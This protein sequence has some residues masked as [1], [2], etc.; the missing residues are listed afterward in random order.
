[1]SGVDASDRS[2]AC[3]EPGMERREP[4]TVPVEGSLAPPRRWR[5]T[6]LAV[7]ATL[8][9]RI[10][11]HCAGLTAD[12]V[13][14]TYRYAHNLGEGRGLVFNPGERV[15]GATEPGVALV[16]GGLHAATGLPVDRLGAAFT[17][18]CLVGLAWLMFVGLARSGRAAEGVVAGS[19]LLAC[20]YLWDCQGAAGPAVL[21]LLLAAAERMERRPVAAGL[22]AG[23]AVWMRPDA[24]LGIALLG[25]DHLVRRRRPAWR[26][27]GVA[28]VVVGLGLL[29]ALSYYGT[30]LPATWLAKRLHAGLRPESWIGFEPFWGFGLRQ[31]APYL[32]PLAVPLV[33]LGAIGL[34]PLARR[35]PA[36]RTLA[37]LGVAMF[38]VYPGLR[39]P[40]F[41]WYAIPTVIALLYGA[42]MALGWLARRAA[43]GGGRPALATAAGLAT[44]A[45]ASSFAAGALDWWRH[46]AERNWRVPVYGTAGEWLRT[47]SAPEQAI[48]FHEIGVLAYTSDRRVE[49]L[50]GL[51]TPRSLPWARQGDVVGAFLAR[52]TEYFLAHSYEGQ[53]AFSPL[54]AREWF[55]RA[56]EEVARL[57][58]GPAPDG[59]VVIYR[60]RPGSEL[61][62]PAPPRPRRS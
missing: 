61:P 62:A 45:A 35:G 8:A 23:A 43:S 37:A 60:R 26:F 24:L 10:A 56:Y 40:F 5:W 31:L 41:S 14:I 16:L 46:G 1:M 21:I 33:A 28:A 20:G 9:A 53:G 57:R 17:A 2:V 36:A 3:T 44:L 29:A 12:D 38:A 32:G 51:V 18:A 42:V 54:L 58:C 4:G 11:L 34:V 13:Y 30:V 19:A 15:F 49:D 27:A 52:P 25:I 55:K 48:A 47:H 50:L 6:V 22:L 59:F 7:W 39:V